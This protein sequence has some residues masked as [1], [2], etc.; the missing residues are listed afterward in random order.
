MDNG[1]VKLLVYADER[2][3]SRKTVA[4]GIFSHVYQGQA[5][6]NLGI[7]DL[8]DVESEYPWNIACKGGSIIIIYDVD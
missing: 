6:D 8:S 1:R 7:R 4:G 2:M 3:A 5:V